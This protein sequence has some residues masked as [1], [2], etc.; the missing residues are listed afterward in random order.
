[1]RRRL[2]WISLAA[3][4]LAPGSA[5][6]LEWDVS[7]WG[8]RRAATEHVHR[9]AVLLE[10]RTEGE[11][12]LKIN[13]GGLS[14]ERETL[15]GISLGAFEMAQFCVGYH[16][17]KTPSLTVLE[18]PFL[19]VETLEESLAVSEAVYRHPA[20]EKDLERW[21]A[22]LLMP[23]PAPALDMVGTGEPRD[24]LDAFQGMRVR[25]TGGIGRAFEAAGAVPNVFTAT[26][27]REAMTTGVIDAVV[28]APHAL[29]A[30]GL[31]ELSDWW[32]ENLDAGAIECPIAANLDAYRDLSADLRYALLTSAEDAL[33]HY[34][35]TYSE[36]LDGWD[37]QLAETDVRAVRMSETELSRFREMAGPIRKQ[38]LARME[39]QGLPGQELYDL[40]QSTLAQLRSPE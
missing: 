16:V 4:L 11:F 38:W 37:G 13:Y 34:V 24:T 26:Q 40:V 35:E 33:D 10:E 36:L 31:L 27:A 5:G 22:L 18:L 8:E 14:N 39:G 23:S 29:E 7:L 15:D 1:M 9:L 2:C 19:G 17:D 32:I 3:L 21:N 25:A 28:A 6:A 20:V 30:N 12:T